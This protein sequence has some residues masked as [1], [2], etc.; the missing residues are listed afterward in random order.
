VAVCVAACGSVILVGVGAVGVGAVGVW[1]MV[2]AWR[3]EYRQNRYP[4]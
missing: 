1:G 4:A 2:G 3:S